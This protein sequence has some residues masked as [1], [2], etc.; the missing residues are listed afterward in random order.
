MKG[1]VYMINWKE[2][3]SDYYGDQIECCD[4]ED[5]LQQVKLIA[6]DDFIGWV[7]EIK[8]VNDKDRY[9]EKPISKT[10]S[11]MCKNILKDKMGD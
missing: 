2:D 8:L 9:I 4:K 5:L 6:D 3:K 7:D 11:K 1:Y 10:L